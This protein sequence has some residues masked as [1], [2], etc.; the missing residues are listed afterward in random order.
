MDE[1]PLC[2]TV[3]ADRYAQSG[4][5][6]HAAVFRRVAH[7]LSLAESAASRVPVEQAFFRNLRRGAIGAG[8]ILANAGANTPGTM[9]NC[10][11][12]PLEIPGDASTA[13]VEAALVRALGEA[14][15]T[16]TMGGGIGYD[17]SPVPPTGAYERPRA[18][19]KGVCAAIDRF[20]TC[21]L[22]C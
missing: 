19:E 11:V 10:F 12:H 21:A 1:Q 7:A 17:F 8:R 13:A 4:E 20:A 6:T 9:I 16:L 2:T 18:E 14:R 3:F 22:A 5:T 15:L